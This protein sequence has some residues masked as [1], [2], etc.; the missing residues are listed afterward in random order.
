MNT[1]YYFQTLRRIEMEIII[2]I[3]IVAGIAWVLMSRKN[4]KQAQ[5]DGIVAPYKVESSTYTVPEPAATTPIP[6]VVEE[7]KVE[8]PAVVAAPAA[9]AVVAAPAV[10]EKP[11][12][13]KPA[14]APKA[15]KAKVAKIVKAEKP[16]KAKKA[17]STA[18]AKPKA[19][20][21]LRVVK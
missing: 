13:A 17:A 15:P 12:K 11:A 21:K 14:P 8:V 7:V 6:L 4:I 9:T 20:R 10:A 18:E 16:T 5:E 3:A 1:K 2:F 19:Q